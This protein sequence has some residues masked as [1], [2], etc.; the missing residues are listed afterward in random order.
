MTKIIIALTQS[1]K[2]V[3]HTSIANC[4]QKLPAFQ[5]Y[6]L[7]TIDISDTAVSHKYLAKINSYDPAA[8]ITLDLA[9]FQLRTQSGEAALNMMSAKIMNLIWGERPEYNAYLSGKISLS[10][11]FF[12][13][14]DFFPAMTEL[15]P[16]IS[17]YRFIGK[18]PSISFDSVISPQILSHLNRMCKIFLTDSMLGTH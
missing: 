8:I 6:R 10:M 11:H 2:Y 9:G 7:I 14:L 12:D 1:S 5:N 18:I 17:Y 15:Y 13:C 4:F 16:N 3:H